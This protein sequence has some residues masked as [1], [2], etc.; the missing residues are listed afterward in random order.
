MLSANM[1]VQNK[2]GMGQMLTIAVRFMRI[3]KSAQ[4][5]HS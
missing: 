2:A 1:F 5:N 4:S 3:C